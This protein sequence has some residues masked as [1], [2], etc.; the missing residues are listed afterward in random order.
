MLFHEGDGLFDGLQQ[1]ALQLGVIGDPG[2]IRAAEL[3][4]LDPGIGKVSK[5]VEAEQQHT[6]RRWYQAV[7]VSGDQAQGF[8]VLLGQPSDRCE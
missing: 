3:A 7:L 1:W 4:N 5:P 2:A 6:A 8:H